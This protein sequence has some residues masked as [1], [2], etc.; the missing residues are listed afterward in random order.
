M[1]RIKSRIEALER[2]RRGAYP[3]GV[4]IIAI[5]E[6]GEWRA[7]YGSRGGTFSTEA[8]AIHFIHQNA[9]QSAPIIVIDI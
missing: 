6:N 5:S 7:E 1:E 9:P 3:S 8:E 4:A 2:Y